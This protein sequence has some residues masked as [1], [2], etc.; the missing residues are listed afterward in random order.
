MERA[1]VLN[2]SDE[3]LGITNSRRAA[4]L[5]MSQ[6]ADVLVASDMVLHS[7][8]REIASPSVIRLRTYVHVP[9]RRPGGA[10][11]L[12]GLRARDGLMCAYCTKRPGATIDHV[13]PRSR[14]GAHTWENTVAACSRCNARKANRTPAECGLTLHVTPMLPPSSIWLTLAMAEFNPNWAPYLEGIG[15]DLPRHARVLAR[16]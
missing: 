9:Y 12:V 3:P 15:L 14:G 7:P 2:A 13:K 1:L 8:S 6:K 11:T 10:P 4:V 5:A 16:V